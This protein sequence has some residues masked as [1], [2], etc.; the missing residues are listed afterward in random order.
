M[1]L[2]FRAAGPSDA[3]EVVRL[4]NAAY[5]VG[6]GRAWT[7]EA[8]LVAGARVTE[9]LFREMVAREGSVVLVAEREGRLVGCAHVQPASGSERE[10]TIGML[11][12]DPAEQAAGVGRAIVAEAERVA[13]ERFG[14]AVVSMRVFTVRPELLAWYERRG[15]RRTGERLAFEPPPTERLLRGPLT[16]ERLVKDL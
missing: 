6:G 9:D 7:T 15:Y 12:V 1:P 4:V 2:A 8:D 16:F 14:A 5:R 11:S 10:C 13:R 3:A